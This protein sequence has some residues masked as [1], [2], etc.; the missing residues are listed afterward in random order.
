MANRATTVPK[1]FLKIVTSVS[2]V[3][4]HLQRLFPHGGRMTGGTI[5]RWTRTI[6]MIE[7]PGLRFHT[8]LEYTLHECVH[9]FA[10]PHAPTPQECPRPCIG[11][12]QAEFGTGF[13]EG[14]TQV[15]TEDI[16]DQQSISLNPH[17]RPYEDFAAVMRAVVP[18]F[19]IDAMARA[20]F[21]GDVAS[22]RASMEARWGA[23]N[24]RAL[25]LHTSAGERKGCSIGFPYSRRPT[26]HGW[27][28]KRPGESGWKT[29][30]ETRQEVTSRLP[31]GRETWLRR[32]R[33]RFDSC[34]SVLT[35]VSAIHNRHQRETDWRRRMIPD[36][37]PRPLLVFRRVGPFAVDKSVLTP[38]LKHQV[39]QVVDFVKANL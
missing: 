28:P 2:Q 8:R 23:N 35:Q 4:K 34:T 27:Q 20:Y 9:L 13:G 12:F 1:K 11:A 3:P 19:G 22:L 15:I 30:S 6:Y 29:S 36:P 38:Q 33:R 37:P 32:S 7:P 26:R 16:M 10:H 31:P 24:L 5:D 14:L 39:K 25:T 21:F 17:D 18:V